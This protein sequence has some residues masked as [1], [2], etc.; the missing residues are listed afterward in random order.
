MDADRAAPEALAALAR[1]QWGIESVHRIRDT[2]Y[3]EDL[4]TG[5]AG[6][7]PQVVA[8]LRNI[9]IS[10]LHIAGITTIT[11]IQALSRDRNRILDVIQL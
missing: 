11:T 1:G 2:A 3:T 9:A 6:D 7:G 5:Y 10:L 8:T 4:S